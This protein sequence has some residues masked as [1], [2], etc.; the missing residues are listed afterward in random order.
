[1]RQERSHE[2]TA[3]LADGKARFLEVTRRGQKASVVPI[4]FATPERW[5]KARG[6][7]FFRY[8]TWKL[9]VVERVAD[10]WQAVHS[11]GKP[12]LLDKADV[13][14]F[15]EQ[16]GDKP[17]QVLQAEEIVAEYFVALVTDRG[18]AP[19]RVLEQMRELLMK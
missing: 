10:R 3:P 12:L 16:V 9:M 13:N 5:S 4:L 8:L 19:P 2:H 7:E 6:G 11:E 14:D 18:A 15:H 1:M 17:G